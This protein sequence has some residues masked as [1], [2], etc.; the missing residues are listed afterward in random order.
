MRISAAVRRSS[1]LALLT[2]GMLAFFLGSPAAMAAAATTLYAFP[3]SGQSGYYPTGTLVRDGNGALYGTT[4]L[5]GAH[6]QGTVFRLNPPAA[7]QTRWTITVLYSFRGGNDGGAPSGGVVRDASGALYG[8]AFSGGANLLG[9][10]FK[11]MPPAPGKAT[12]TQTVLHAFNYSFVFGIKDGASPAAELIR[13]PATG[14]L[15]GTTVGGGTAHPQTGVGFG[16][17]FKLTPPAP[18]KTACNK[19]EVL[20]GPTPP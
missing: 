12:W 20:F 7:G 3:Q 13:D 19:A 11:L 4:F 18:G 6:N 14:T 10:V 2:A 5:G 9:V 15:Y 17:V 8:T 1:I 16:T